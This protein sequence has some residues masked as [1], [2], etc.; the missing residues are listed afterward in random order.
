MK[1]L[2]EVLQELKEIEKSR[3]DIVLP[4]SSLSMQDNGRIKSNTYGEFIPSEP[5]IK[6]ICSRYKLSSPH[7]DVLRS[8]GREDLVAETFNH[9]LQHDR[10]FMKLR[11]VDG[12]RIKGIVERTYKPFDDYDVFGQVNDYIEQ[13]GFDYDLDIVNQD[14]EFTR[15]RFIIKDFERNMGMAHENGI[16]NDIVFG[17]FEI[18]NSEIG[19]KMGINS[20]IYRQVCTN[21]MMGLMSDEDNKD[22]FYKRGKDFNPFSR[23]NILQNGVANAVDKSDKNIDMFKKTK[24]IIVNEPQFELRKIGKKYG[25]GGVHVDGFVENWNRE[26]QRNYYGVLNSITSYAQSFKKDYTSRSKFE[27]IANDLMEKVAS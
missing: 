26:Q 25:I 13:N 24:D 18:T 2:E 19:S 12:D 20:L 4:M 16:D 8:N 6:K 10:Q 9:F 22:I 1:K 3:N 14:D 21:G 23:K 5:T 7:M 15:L 27:F 11:T 17:G